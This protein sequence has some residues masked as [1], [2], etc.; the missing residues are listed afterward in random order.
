MLP[1]LFDRSAKII[2]FLLLANFLK[3]NIGQTH[4]KYSILIDLFFLTEK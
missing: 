3:K 4:E 2:G 1:Y